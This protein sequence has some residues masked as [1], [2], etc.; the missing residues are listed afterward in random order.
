MPVVWSFNEGQAGQN[1]GQGPQMSNTS[2]VSHKR[3]PKTL[4]L[5]PYIIFKEETK[6]FI[7]LWTFYSD[8]AVMEKQ[9]AL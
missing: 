3:N 1:R 8:R 9:N 6:L 2:T 5:I 7:L 4:E